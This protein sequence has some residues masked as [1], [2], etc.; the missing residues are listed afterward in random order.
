MCYPKVNYYVISTYNNTQFLSVTQW[1]TLGL[2]ILLIPLKK[3]FLMYL[4]VFEY[5]I[6]KKQ[7]TLCKEYI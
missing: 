5:K 3:Y 7:Y 2:T 6:C 4:I 1:Y